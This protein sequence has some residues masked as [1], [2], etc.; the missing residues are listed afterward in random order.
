[1]RNTKRKSFTHIQRSNAVN[2]VNKLVNQGIGLGDARTL[3]ASKIGL[4]RSSTLSKWAR[5][6]SL[7]TVTNRITAAQ[8]INNVRSKNTKVM[9]N[10]NGTTKP[11]ITSVSLH[12]PGQG[13]ITLDHQLLQVISRWAGYTN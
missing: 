6:V 4:Q 2:K 10:T 8:A 3:V 5:Q 13:N 7:D 12:V 11:H 1:M 9:Q